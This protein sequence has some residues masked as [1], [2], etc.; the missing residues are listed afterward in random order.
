[1]TTKITIFQNISMCHVVSNLQFRICKIYRF[2]EQKYNL[3]CK[4]KETRNKNLRCTMWYDD[5]TRL[6][7]KKKPRHAW[8]CITRGPSS[9]NHAANLVQLNDDLVIASVHINSI[10]TTA[11]R[12]ETVVCIYVSINMYIEI[13]EC[14]LQHR[15]IVKAFES[16]LFPGRD[17]SRREEENSSANV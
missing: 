9:A 11:L 4:L 6:K 16:D 10:C 12:V 5:G 3:L 7:D 13:R 14:A 1:M 8:T 17:G 2:L 15:H